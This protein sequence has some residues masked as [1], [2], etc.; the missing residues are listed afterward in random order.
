MQKIHIKTYTNRSYEDRENCSYECA[1]D[2][3]QKQYTLQYRTVPILF[4]L[5]LMKKHVILLA[6]L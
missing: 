2:C 1:N 5:I 3:A 6:F 4:T